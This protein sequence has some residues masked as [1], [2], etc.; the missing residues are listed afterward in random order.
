M[1]RPLLPLGNKAP[2]IL[3]TLGAFLAISGFVAGN[4]QMMTVGVVAAAL[5]V[6]AFPL[7][8]LLLGH[9]EDPPEDR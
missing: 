2:W 6:V 5:W 9:D 7:S 8:R 3:L 1:A 4:A